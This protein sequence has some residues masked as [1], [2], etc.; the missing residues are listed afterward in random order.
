MIRYRRFR[1]GSGNS[2]QG[3]PVGLMVGFRVGFTVIDDVMTSDDS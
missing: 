1:G 2:G 3:S